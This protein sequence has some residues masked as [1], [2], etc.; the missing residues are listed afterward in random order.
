MQ[1][2]QVRNFSN[3][4]S[5][6]SFRSTNETKLPQ[7]ISVMLMVRD[8][9]FCQSL[10]GL[11]DLYNFSSLWKFKLVGEADSIKQATGIILKEQPAII[12]LD[13]DLFNNQ[14]NG[15]QAVTKLRRLSENTTSKIKSKILVISSLGEESSVFYAMQAGASGYLLKQNLPSQLEAAITTTL[16]NQVFLCPEIAARFF[17]YFY[18]HHSQTALPEPVESL[19]EQTEMDSFSLGKLTSREREVLELLIEGYRNQEIANRL[20]ITVATVKAHLTTIFEKLGVQSR[21]QAIVKS[22]SLGLFVESNIA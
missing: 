1:L 14:D 8:L 15:I 20:F 2:N 19:D 7:A 18:C 11:L 13:W 22:L 4:P 12:F 10:Q 16:N 3:Q 6:H 17:R 21:S 5:L 9:H